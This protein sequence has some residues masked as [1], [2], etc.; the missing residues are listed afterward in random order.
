MVEKETNSALEAFGSLLRE[1]RVRCGYTV[2]EVASRLK[3]T[4]RVVRAI[5]DGDM[6]SMPHAVYASGFIRA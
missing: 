5:E 4:A 3:I 2:D 6:D 1:E